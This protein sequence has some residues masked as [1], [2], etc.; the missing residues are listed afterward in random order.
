MVQQDSRD[1]RS[2]RVHCSEVREGLVVAQGAALL[3]RV[4]WLV[5][6]QAREAGLPESACDRPMGVREV[7]A[8][9]NGDGDV[10]GQLAA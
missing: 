3:P 9:P 2:C 5:L 8:L 1:A 4:P 7:R 6:A 10:A